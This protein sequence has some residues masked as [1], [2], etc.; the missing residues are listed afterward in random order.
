MNLKDADTLTFVF[1]FGICMY[2]HVY[3]HTY[4]TTIVLANLHKNGNFIV[5]Q[6]NQ[7]EANHSHRTTGK[8]PFYGR[9]QQLLLRNYIRQSF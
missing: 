4:T 1:M 7:L 8:F 5:I 9:R 6:P 3:I 2:V